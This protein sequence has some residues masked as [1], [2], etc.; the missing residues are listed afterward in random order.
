M[1]KGRGSDSHA[2]EPSPCIRSNEMMVPVVQAEA[3]GHLRNDSTV[4]A[5]AGRATEHGRLRHFQTSVKLGKPIARGE[6]VSSMRVDTGRVV[7]A[8][9]EAP[10]PVTTWP[11][12]SE[13]QSEEFQAGQGE[14][15]GEVPL[16]SLTALA[17]SGMPEGFN[18]VRADKGES[19]EQTADGWR[20][21]YGRPSS[22]KSHSVPDT[23]NPFEPLVAL[24]DSHAGWSDGDGEVG[25]GAEGGGDR[26]TSG[27]CLVDAIQGECA[28]AS[29]RSRCG[30]SRT[31]ARRRRRALGPLEAHA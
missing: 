25:A 29:R 20:P 21:G 8:G 7:A 17:P 18:G 1:P 11:M 4:I 14:A 27:P 16:V 9:S 15:C 13:Y 23:H 6:P 2:L 19:P 10:T 26:V 5:G 12:S 30:G 31:R 28:G 3:D 22:S 24:Q